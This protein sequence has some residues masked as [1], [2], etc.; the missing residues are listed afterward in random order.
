MCATVSPPAFD[1]YIGIDYS[2]AETPT[3]SLKGLRVYLAECGSE[4]PVEVAP[5]P[6]PRRYWTRRGIAEWLVERL[7]EDR[8]TIVGIDHGFSFPI[9]YFEHHRLKP[10]WPTFLEDFQRHW[11]TDDEY[12]YVDF[13]RDGSRGNGAMRGGNAKWRRLTELHTR[14]AKSVF[15][16][17]VQGSVAKSTHAGLPWLLHLLRRLGARVHFWP[18]DG[19]KVPSGR[20]AVVEVYPALWSR[21]YPR[22]DRTQHQHDAYAVAVWMRDA[23]QNGTLRATLEPPLVAPIRATAE[24]E[25]W[26]LGTPLE[27]LLNMA[28]SP[29]PPSRRLRAVQSRPKPFPG[30]DIEEFLDCAGKRRRFRLQVYANGRF[31]EA[32]EILADDVPGARI[33]LPIKRGASP[34]WGEIR[35]RI[36]ERLARRDLV[37]DEHGRLVL[38]A[39][40]L[41]GQL[42]WSEE[43]G[44]ALIVDD[45][46]LSWDEVGRLLEAYEGFGV[47]LEIR[48]AVEE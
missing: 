14:G 44:P 27:G 19:W 45:V 1:R 26:I 13:V 15:H 20:S 11:P 10:H 48:D 8:A 9:R 31:L 38:V 6:S 47:R 33:A 7:S 29:G 3:S 41:R 12:T 28:C 25:G 43:D 4:P 46:I 32:R 2:G 36:R 23:D 39:D 17:D 30:G 35:K 40:G 18:F 34:P 21:S 37:A 42:T 5:P 16:F 22:E 24:I